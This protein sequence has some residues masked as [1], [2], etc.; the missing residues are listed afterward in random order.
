M[1]LLLDTNI[2]LYYLSGDKRL[3]DFLDGIEINLSF[4]TVVELLSYPS[5]TQ[6]EESRI[7][8]FLLNC[9][10]F[11][12]SEELRNQAIAI[13]KKTQNETA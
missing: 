8:E 9:T 3:E 12:E 11:S 7:N 10:I 2:V 6:K 1:N 13:K 4:I 5:L